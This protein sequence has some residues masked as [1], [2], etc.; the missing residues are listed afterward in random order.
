M[1]AINDN[2]EILS[3][4]SNIG[5]A[6]KLASYLSE[7][8]VANHQFWV[9]DQYSFSRELSRR[10]W[11]LVILAIDS[12][13]DH[14]PACILRYP[15]TPFIA[16]VPRRRQELIDELLDFGVVDVGSFSNHQRLQHTIARALR[17][18]AAN[19]K[20]KKIARKYR[21]HE[22]LL[23]NLLHS[24]EQP[25]AFVHQ[26]VH[27]Y[28]NPAY[29]RALGLATDAEAMATPVLDLLATRDRKRMHRLLRDLQQGKLLSAEL[30]TRIRQGHGNV[31]RV[32]FQLEQTHFQGESVTQI[33]IKPCARKQSGNNA[34][35]NSGK[36]RA[37]L[38]NQPV[39]QGHD[40]VTPLTAWTEIASEA[41]CGARLQIAVRPIDTESDT[42]SVLPD[43]PI[44]RPQSTRFSLTPELLPV[45]DSMQSIEKLVAKLRR[46]DLLEGFD[47]WLLYN[48][49]SSLKKR[50]KK[51]QNCFFYVNLFSKGKQLE[52]LADWLPQLMGKFQLPDS[53]LNLIVDINGLT[54]TTEQ[55]VQI[56]EA[57]RATGVGVGS[58]ETLSESETI[59]R[60][61]LVHS[62]RE[63]NNEITG[64]DSFDK[65]SVKAL[66]MPVDFRLL[67]AYRQD[68]DTNA[69]KNICRRADASRTNPINDWALETANTTAGPQNNFTDSSSVSFTQSLSRDAKTG[70]TGDES[71]VN[72]I[73]A[74]ESLD[75]T[76]AIIRPAIKP[77][78]VR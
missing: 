65:T 46:L 27:S 75:L 13:R 59:S 49:A 4:V 55:S 43:N 5:Q 1:E 64:M 54:D 21:E 41:L 50:L 42:A 69:G 12:K 25:L 30:E 38:V 61:E 71:N 67:E 57:L 23:N 58:V 47:Q 78:T 72:R 35:P 44:Q 2:V 74:K 52:R 56:V 8:D 17:E 14:I 33:R 3:L 51:Q 66:G 37:H 76:L 68:R 26:G 63:A 9:E 62:M 28:A 39:T 45:D 34:E 36:Q 18:A 31:A 20:H 11:D 22:T 77:A 32:K 10:H 16:I 53:R 40:L 48:A 15:D 73:T 70:R 24:L 29:L 7:A 6:E 19:Q 60:L